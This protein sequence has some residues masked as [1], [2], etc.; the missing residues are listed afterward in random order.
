MLK[1][2]LHTFAMIFC[3]CLFFSTTLAQNALDEGK[4]LF[5]AGQYEKAKAIFIHVLK[6]NS[7][8]DEANHFLGRIYLHAGD[9]DHAQEY[10]ERAVEIDE[11]NID[12]HLWL[13]N[14]Y[15]EKARRASFL[16]AG[17]WAGKW[18]A[19]LERAFEIDSKNLEA[20]R[21][22]I[23]YYLNAPAICG[24]DKEKGKSLAEETIA[25][26]EV[27][28]RLLL[29]SAYQQTQKVELAVAEYQKVLNTDSQNGAA[30]NALGYIFLRQKDYDAAEQNFKKYI[31]VAPADPN[32]YDSLGDYYAERGRMDEAMPQYQ[33]ALETD[34]TFSVSRFKLAEAYEKKQMPEKAV[35]H[36]QKLI[37]I[38]PAYIRADDAGKRI[39][40][41]KK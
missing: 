25:I 29:A 24:G 39:K 13:G 33:K 19:A 10:L 6:S 1:K 21:R 7:D 41:L 22:L 20:R 17:R 40:K 36:Y 32:S 34:S 35:Y 14:V 30:Y 28:G 38:T 26:N 23:N 16:S 5:N 37:A 18:K 4:R 27:Q 2:H 11:G 12:Y 31:A 3:L 9:F 15:R 8:D